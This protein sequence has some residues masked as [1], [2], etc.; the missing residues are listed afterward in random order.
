ML[1]YAN[2]DMVGHT[3]VFEAACRAV[4]TIDNCVGRVVEKLMAQGSA[5]V[6]TADHGNAEQM[7]DVNGS[8]YTAHTLN[9]VAC[10][11]LTPT[12][13][14]TLRTRGVLADVAP[15]VLQLMGLKQPHTM[16]GISL[17]TGG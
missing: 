9:D 16:T 13:D 6:L 12:Q 11:V 7:L 5:V 3:G 2:L 4:T 17:I 15:T 14:I 8:I 10:V 1:N